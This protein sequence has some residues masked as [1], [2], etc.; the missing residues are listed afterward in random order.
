MTEK[1]VKPIELL[2]EIITNHVLLLTFF[3]ASSI[4]L[5]LPD[6]VLNRIHILNFKSEYNW[7]IGIVFLIT[8]SALSAKTFE[9]IKNLTKPLF[10]NLKK[11]SYLHNLSKE[12]KGFLRHYIINDENTISVY[13]ND[14]IAGGLAKNCVIYLSSP[15]IIVDVRFGSPYNIDPWAKKYLKNNPGLLENFEEY[16]VHSKGERFF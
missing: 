16:R 7:L 15:G 3:I 14:G 11:K 2:K 6:S 8:L 12:E 4:L 5:F 1:F 10:L 9:Y 13:M